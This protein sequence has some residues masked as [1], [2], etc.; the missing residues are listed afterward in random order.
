VTQ[1]TELSSSDATVPVGTP[2][3]QT[4]PASPTPEVDATGTPPTQTT[5]PG[6]RG[7]STLD[8]ETQR[9]AEG[10]DLLMNDPHTRAAIETA[11]AGKLGE[12]PEPGRATTP[13]TPP[14]GTSGDGE[15]VTREQFNQVQDALRKV[16]THFAEQQVTELRTKYPDFQSLEPQIAPIVKANPNLSFEQGYLLARQA[17]DG[18]K[19]APAPRQAAPPPTETGPGGGGTRTHEAPDPIARAQERMRSLPPGS[20]QLEDALRIAYDTALETGGE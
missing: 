1:S 6:R 3:A 18:G 2:P 14:P 15:Y 5:E 16:V 11:I 19:P 7:E 4:P 10:Y 9:K 12:V 8:Y 20:R 17:R 13:A